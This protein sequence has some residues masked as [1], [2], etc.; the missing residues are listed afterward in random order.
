MKR[1]AIF[2]L[3]LTLAASSALAG[4]VTPRGEVVL[5]GKNLTVG[6]VFPGAARNAD[7]VLAPAPKP[8]ETMT[9]YAED[10]KRISD[11][12]SLGWDA[13]ASAARTVVKSR[14]V[15]VSREEMETTLAKEMNRLLK[16][17]SFEMQ[18]GDRDA[19]LYLPPETGSELRVDSLKYDLTRGEF[20]GALAAGKSRKEVSGRLYALTQVPVLKNALRAGDVISNSDIDFVSMRDADL[21]DNTI[22]DA[23]KL[24]GLTPRRGISAMKPVTTTD[25]VMPTLVKKGEAVTMALNHG[26]IRLTAQGKALEDGAEGEVVRILNVSSRQTVEAVVTGPKTVSVRMGG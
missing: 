12:F 17:R 11:A 24:K 2:A 23:E 1:T 22:I 5:D 16:G 21:S 10:L 25:V 8:G 19:A 14:A 18:I 20:R 4:N 9:L 3:I 7:H 13:R 15:E 6:D 26:N